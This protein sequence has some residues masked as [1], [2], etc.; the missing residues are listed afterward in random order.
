M[1]EK[2][3]ELKVRTESPPAPREEAGWMPFESLR[4][5]VDRLFDDF[6]TTRWDWP[7]LRPLGRGMLAARPFQWAPAPAMDIVEKDGAFRL[8]VELPG[9]DAADIEVKVSDG[10]ITVS[11]EKKE[12]EE[13]KEGDFR[14]SE[15]RYGKFERSFSLP[16]SIETAKI[17]ASFSKGVLTVVMPKSASALAAE[18]KIEVKAA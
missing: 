17:E 16:D 5:E 11:G 3:T 13:A 4:R 2:P 12:E 9:L 10:M 7:L 8:T 1:A 15:R 6:G 14:L 18:K